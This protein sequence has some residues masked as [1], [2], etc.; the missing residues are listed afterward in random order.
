MFFAL[1]KTVAFFF[2]PSN[3]LLLVLL[4]GCV[5]LGAGLRRTGRWC[6]GLSVAALILVGFLPLGRVLTNVLE[7][8]FPRWDTHGRTPDGIVILGGAISPV[9]AR[10]RGDV[11]LNE[12]AERITV[13][14]RLARD[15]PKARIIFTSGDASLLGDEGAEADYLFPVLD[16]MGVPRERVTL[17]RRA[18]NTAENAL[19]S[20]EIAQPKPGET[21][22]LVTSAFHMPRAMGV[23]RRAGFHVEAYPVDWRTPRRPLLKPNFGLV[24]GL[25]Q[26][27]E[28]VHEWEGLLAYRLTGRTDAFFPAP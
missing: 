6:V 3:F 5:L 27:D 23:F 21:W 14:A 12:S 20:K 25:M 7:N 18:R 26:F 16:T 4:I 8:R 9:V 2:V 19:F 17:E 22:L 1:S 24:S 28:A 10:S 13:I 11:T 15:Y